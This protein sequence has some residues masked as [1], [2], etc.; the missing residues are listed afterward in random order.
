VR[1]KGRIVS[2]GFIHRGAGEF[3]A[4]KAAATAAENQANAKQRKANMQ[5]KPATC[6]RH[7]A[8]LH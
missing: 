5:F 6:N 2:R 3:K 4:R 7:V 8:L 1:L